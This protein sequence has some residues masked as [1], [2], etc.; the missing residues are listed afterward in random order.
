LG[1]D[2]N[3][4]GFEVTEAGEVR[5]PSE[6]HR[7]GDTPA[8]AGLVDCS[9]PLRAGRP[10]AL[11]KLAELASSGSASASAASLSREVSFETVWG[12]V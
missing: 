8:D 6:S 11:N 12:G 4:E 1:L 9:K 2:D 7:K 5:R 3:A 10:T